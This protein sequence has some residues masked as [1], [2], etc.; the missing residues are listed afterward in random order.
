MSFHPIQ[1]AQD[2]LQAWSSGSMT[3]RH[4]RQSLVVLASSG[5]L[6]CLV[7]AL[8]GGKTFHAFL[9][10][11]W[12]LGMSTAMGLGIWAYRTVRERFAERPAARR[13]GLAAVLA[14][15]PVVI[16]IGERTLAAAYWDIPFSLEWGHVHGRL[17]LALLLLVVIELPG[18]L[19]R[20]RS[21]TTG[22][23]LAEGPAP[24][25]EGP[26]PAFEVPTRAGLRRIPAGD[27]REVRAAG[28]YVEIRFNG[29]VYL[30]RETLAGMEETLTPHGFQRVH[31]S[32]LL[33]VEAVRA[34]VR[35]SSGGVVARLDD[36]TEVP[37]GR[38]F[39][40]GLRQRLRHLPP[41]A[42]GEPTA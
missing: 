39:H 34:L 12:G 33:R 37:V 15:L 11:A 7:S 6:Y 2:W 16:A 25:S 32:H 38:A 29:S 4:W 9:A 14:V 13:L 23:A 18:W 30:L 42:I 5:F 35:R 36:G 22:R 8:S 20:V 19:R 28:N 3:W 17:P 40:D 26:T 21:D 27:I 10:L 41:V 24:V 1:P 31:R